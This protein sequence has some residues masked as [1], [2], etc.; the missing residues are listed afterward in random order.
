MSIV[1]TERLSRRTKFLYGIGD[2]GFSLTS[3]LIGVYYL[4]FLTDVVG[5]RPA[6][7][8]LAMMVAKQWDWINDPLIGHLSDRTRT[9]WGRRR[10]FLLFG[11]VPF[12][13]AFALMWW[14]PPL[15]N[16]GGLAAYYTAVYALYDTAATFVYM[17]YFALTPELTTDYDERTSLTTYRMAF[18]ILGSLVAFTVPW[19]IVRSFRPENAARILLNGVLFAVISALPLLLT[20]AGTREK[21]EFQTASRPSLR[22]SLRAALRNRPFVLGIAVFLLTWL[23]TNIVQAVLLYFIRYWLHLEAQSDT[24]FAVIFI[25]ALVVLPLWE[26]I[27]RRTDKRR[28][29]AIGIA[30]WAVVQIVLVSLGPTTR[31][32]V[33]LVLSTLAGIGVAAAHVLP[34]AMIPDAVEWDELQT[35]QRHEGMFY[36]LV[37]LI[38][39]A[40]TGLALFLLGLALDW[41]GYVANAD[42]QPISAVTAIRVFTGP[43]P[44]VLLCAGIAF[45]ALYPLGRH[46]HLRV[47]QAIAER[48]RKLS[49]R[50][51][52]D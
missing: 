20:F 41:S 8:G 26:L 10:P 30:F 48:R 17:P 39:K 15:Q 50:T 2:T 24:I 49:V 23:A 52:R 35:G 6:L 29:Y 33:I 11:F 43:V 44:A 47:R 12:A 40:A 22:Q 14:K 16:Q 9:R 42:Q 51:D 5:L 32:S 4:L 31:F 37:M 13:L 1:N 18:S 7:A 34:W 36:S 45:A 27:S 25:T 3:T 28:A 38:Q 21:K 46:G 19:M